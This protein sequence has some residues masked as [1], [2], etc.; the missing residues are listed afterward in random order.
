M[1]QDS[2][3]EIVRQRGFFFLLEAWFNDKLQGGSRKV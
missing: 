3:R 1:D 2:K